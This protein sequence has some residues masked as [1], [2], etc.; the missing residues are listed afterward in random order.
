MKGQSASP[1]NIGIETELGYFSV[2]L[3]DGSR[4]VLHV[5]EQPLLV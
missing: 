3:V 4:Q 2:F 1:G 5:S